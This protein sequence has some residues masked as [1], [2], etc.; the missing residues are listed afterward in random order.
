MVSFSAV[1]QAG[2]ARRRVVVS[3]GVVV[4][5][6][7]GGAATAV[8]EPADMQWQR[9]GD[10][11]E[12]AKRRG[13][14]V[15]DEGGAT[16][17]KLVLRKLGMYFLPFKEN[18]KRGPSM[19]SA[20]HSTAREGL[21]P[22]KEI[23]ASRLL[24]CLSFRSPRRPKRRNVSN[25][26]GSEILLRRRRRTEYP[27]SRLP[28]RRP[29]RGLFSPRLLTREPRSKRPIEKDRVASKQTGTGTYRDVRGQV[30]AANL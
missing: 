10:H 1:S 5:G 3:A 8:G 9:G 30:N 26:R 4:V 18:L 19:P 17:S 24:C 2:G 29:S 23:S 13:G 22:V 28:P 6:A 16:G 7:L 20:F 11:V 27:G 12:T 15:G 21:A 14:G 25:V